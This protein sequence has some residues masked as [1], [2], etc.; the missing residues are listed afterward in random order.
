MNAEYKEIVFKG[1]KEGKITKGI[2]VR[3]LQPGHVL[4]NVTHSG[5]CGTDV[6]FRHKDMVLGHEGV[7]IVEEVGEGC[8]RFKKGD[9]VGWGYQHDCCGQCLQCL[10]GNETFCPTQQMYGCC[11]LDQGSFSTKAIW[12]EAF[13]FAIPSSILLSDA[14][15][16]MC[17]GATVFAAMY[18]HGVRPSDTVGI[19]GIGGLGHLAIQFA[20]KMGCEVVVFSSTETKKE[21]AMKLGASQFHATRGVKDLASVCN[22]RLNHLLV[23]TSQQPNWEQYFQILAP[24]STVF[25]LTISE[26]DLR[27]P[28]LRL[29][30]CGIR[31]VGSVIAS[32][33]VHTL[34]LDFAGRN[35]IK[36]IT[37]EFPMTEAGIEDAFEKLERG[38]VRYRAVIV[39]K[40]ETYQ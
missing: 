40:P 2:T 4:V 17:G 25:P 6:H 14:A 23:T 36:P 26:G 22:K 3:K 34:M 7:G 35:K 12:K 24:S 28:Y 37:M 18:N 31:I 33:Y 13:L 16:L 27:T 15:P 5:L 39:P 1:S 30:Q 21:E 8:M 29:V 20:A 10:S 32:R 38:Q 9:H 11:D 19:V